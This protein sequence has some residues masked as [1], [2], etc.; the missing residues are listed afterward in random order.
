MLTLV[1]KLTYQFLKNYD[2]KMK[3][4]EQTRKEEIVNAL[5][6]GIGILFCLIALPFLL[7]DDF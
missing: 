1:Y 6:H 7:M 3:N 2:W 5:S 4:R